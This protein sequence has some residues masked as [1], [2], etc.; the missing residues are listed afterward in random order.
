LAYEVIFSSYSF[1]PALPLCT[2]TSHAKISAKTAYTIS[3]P[4]RST[5]APNTMTRTFHGLVLSLI[6]LGT[7]V[8]I[9]MLSINVAPAS[10]ASTLPPA[11]SVAAVY[12]PL[13][14]YHEVFVVDGNGALNVVWKAANDTWNAPFALTGDGFTKPALTNLLANAVKYSPPGD[15]VRVRVSRNADMIQVAISDHGPGIPEAFRAQLFQ[16]FAQADSSTSRAKGGTGLGL[17]ITKGIIERLTFTR[18][19][20]H[21]NGYT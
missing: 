16:K 1:L 15:M 9:G 7:P 19:H 5:E 2:K 6:L 20:G 12:Q 17:S 14:E 21:P 11:A 18:F 10:G 13:N 4:K 3:T 8:L